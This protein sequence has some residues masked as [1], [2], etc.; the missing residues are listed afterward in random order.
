MARVLPP[1]N[2]LFL[3]LERKSVVNI[4]LAENTN[5]RI[6]GTVAGFDEFMNIVLHDA[7][8]IDLKTSEIREFP[9]LMLKGDCIALIS[10]NS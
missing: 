2:V 4:W 5:A 7:K 1:I 9:S 3:C 6:E 8:E 10:T